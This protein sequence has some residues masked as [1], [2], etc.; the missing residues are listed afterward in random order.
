MVTAAALRVNKKDQHS[1]RPLGALFVFFCF[2]WV[3]KRERQMVYVHLWSLGAFTVVAF[4]ECQAV[5]IEHELDVHK[6]EV[7]SI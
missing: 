2:S 3:L 6:E 1:G 4:D 7:V 5:S